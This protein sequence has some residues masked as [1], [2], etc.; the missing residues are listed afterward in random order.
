MFQLNEYGSKCDL[1]HCGK[2]ID[3]Y[4][5]VQLLDMR[6]CNNCYQVAYGKINELFYKTI[7]GDAF[8]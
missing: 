6:F 2:W 8:K 1:N 4:K 3:P 5:G 7:K